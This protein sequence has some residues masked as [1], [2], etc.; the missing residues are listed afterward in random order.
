MIVETVVASGANASRF[1]SMLSLE[2]VSK[3]VALSVQE[4]KV[5]SVVKVLKKVEKLGVAPLKLVNGFGLD[6][7]KREFQRILG[8]GEV[9]EA[10]DLLEALRGKRCAFATL[11][12]LLSKSKIIMH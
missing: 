2:F 9:E 6:S 8:S 3:G 12:L 4:G 7:L 11:F 5:K 1:A 10:V